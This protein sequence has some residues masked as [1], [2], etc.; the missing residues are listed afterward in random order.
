MIIEV[1][2]LRG[3]SALEVLGV[4]ELKLPAI[5]QKDGSKAENLVTQ[6]GAGMLEIGVRIQA[7][8]EA[9]RNFAESGSPTLRP[10]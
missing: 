2:E 3:R 9:G 10:N 7:R 4:A 6:R 1:S 8:V 5:V